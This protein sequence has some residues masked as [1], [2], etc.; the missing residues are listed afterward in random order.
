MLFRRSPHILLI[1]LEII[2]IRVTVKS[3]GDTV[4]TAADSTVLN[5]LLSI[6]LKE[7]NKQVVFLAAAGA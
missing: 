5:E 3:C 4:R 2:F 6:P 7:I 1:H